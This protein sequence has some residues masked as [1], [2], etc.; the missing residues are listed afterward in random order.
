[1]NARHRGHVLR[2]ILSLSLFVFSF[3]F[4][5]RRSRVGL[6]KGP[7]TWWAVHCLSESIPFQTSFILVETVFIVTSS[8]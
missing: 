6:Y 8:S 4:K 5:V 2:R 7:P 3:F 1:M